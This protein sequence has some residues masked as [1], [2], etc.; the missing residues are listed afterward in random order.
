MTLSPFEILDV[1]PDADDTAI[2][3]AY[4]A[5]VKTYPPERA[6]QR[7]QTIRHAYEKIRDRRARIEYAL[8][9][10]PSL[11]E[12][13]RMA[14]GADSPRPTTDQLRDLFAECL[15]EH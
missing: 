4:L 12:I 5:G 1:S 2:R 7:F 11:A 3:R 15:D 8:F 13:E 9:H 6:P 14:H 10:C